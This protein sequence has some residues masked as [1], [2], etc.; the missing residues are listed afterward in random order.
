MSTTATTAEKVP[1]AGKQS[2]PHSHGPDGKKLPVTVITGFLGSGKTTLLSVCAYTA[3]R[4]A[5]TGSG[6]AIAA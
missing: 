3:I 4:F 1:E 5:I 6:Y 2:T